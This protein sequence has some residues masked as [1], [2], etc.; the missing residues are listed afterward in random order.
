MELMYAAGI[1]GG[2]D[3]SLGSNRI[4]SS[5][6]EELKNKTAE[7]PFSFALTGLTLLCNVKIPPL[8]TTRVIANK[9]LIVT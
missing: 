1:G 7:A 9:Y 6:E 2:S 5:N 3:L 4:L 8:C